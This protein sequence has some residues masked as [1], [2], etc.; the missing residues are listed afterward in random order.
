MLKDALNETASKA[1][2]VIGATSTGA[3]AVVKTTE[4]KTEEIV[5]SLPP[6]VI[7]MIQQGVETGTTQADWATYASIASIVGVG[8]MV[9]RFGF[10]IWHKMKFESPPKRRSNDE[11]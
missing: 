10:E 3:G 5:N 8:A 7:T 2:L 9:I 1:F 6:E 4:R 11:S